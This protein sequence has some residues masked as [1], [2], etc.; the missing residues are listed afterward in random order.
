MT[1]FCEVEHPSEEEDTRAWQSPMKTV[2]LILPIE[3]TTVNNP[4]VSSAVTI[5]VIEGVT[6][7]AC[8]FIL[9]GVSNFV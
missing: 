6:A 2:T 4:S 9:R 1:V 3:A 5:V 7:G 8:V